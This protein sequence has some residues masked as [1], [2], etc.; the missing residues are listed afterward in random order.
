MT[1]KN[2]DPKPNKFIEGYIEVDYVE[3]PVCPKCGKEL[4]GE[5]MSCDA[6]EGQTDYSLF[7]NMHRIKAVSLDK[8]AVKFEVILRIEA[9]PKKSGYDN[10]KV[11]LD[12]KKGL[13]QYFCCEECYKVSKRKKGK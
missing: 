3:K 2:C 9:A 8:K 13:F 1:C 4:L 6:N 7:N 11:I 12:K 5:E 10:I